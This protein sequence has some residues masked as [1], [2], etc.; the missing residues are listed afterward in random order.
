M[1]VW[2]VLNPEVCTHVKEG[3]SMLQD[4]L[5]GVWFVLTV[6]NVNMK[7]VGL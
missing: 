2:F 5:T 6:I 4:E 1:K 3:P 7:L